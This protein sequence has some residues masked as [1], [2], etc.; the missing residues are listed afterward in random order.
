MRRAESV[1]SLTV[2]VLCLAYLFF[3]RQMDEFGTVTEPGAAFVPGVLGVVGFAVSMKL[4]F[5]SLRSPEKANKGEKI[6][7]DGLLRFLGYIAASLIFI[8]MFEILGASVAIFVLV[9]VLTKILGSRGWVQPVGLAIA[10][11]VI[12]YVLFFTLLDVPLPRG[13][14]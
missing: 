1:F 9:L 10:S 13:I 8:P 12:A 6:P 14:F 5:T 7:R 4:F 11:S 2:A 3:V